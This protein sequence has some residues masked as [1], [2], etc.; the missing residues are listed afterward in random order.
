MAHLPQRLASV[1]SDFIFLGTTENFQ[2]DISEH[3]HW[4]RIR[5]QMASKNG[6]PAGLCVNAFT[7]PPEMLH[8]CVLQFHQAG[9]KRL[10]QDELLQKIIAHAY[11]QTCWTGG[12]ERVSAGKT[13]PV[14]FVAIDRSNSFRNDSQTQNGESKQ[15]DVGHFIFGKQN[16]FLHETARANKLEIFRE[17]GK[18]AGDLSVELLERLNAK[19]FVDRFIGANKELGGRIRIHRF[20]PVSGSH[21]ISSLL[22]PGQ[23]ADF[24]TD[25]HFLKNQNVL[26]A[27]N[28][29][30][31]LNFPEEY[32]NVWCAMNDPVGLLVEN[33][34]LRQLPLSRR[35]AILVDKNGRATIRIVSLADFALKLPWEAA[36]RRAD[37]ERIFFLDDLSQIGKKIVVYSPA[38]QAAFPR[39][40][41][42]SPEGDVVDF[43]VV[44][45]NI[46]EAKQGGGLEIP[47]NGVV[48]SCPIHALPSDELPQL[49]QKFGTHVPFHLLTQKFGLEEIQTAVSAGPILLENGHDLPDHSFEPFD[50][51]EQF[52]PAK[53]RENRTVQAGIVPTRFPHDVDKSRAP[54]TLLGLTDDNKFILTVIDGRDV[55]HSPGATLKEAAGIAK[56]LGCTHALNLDGGGSSVL[57]ID[58]KEKT[59]NPL[60]PGIPKGI[61]NI[62]SDSGHRDRL[63]PAPLLV[64]D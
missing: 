16:I 50:A 64:I 34:R 11:W 61:V 26:A 31:F 8:P 18:F 20:V 5:C 60:L 14:A 41:Q 40:E 52:L 53:W 36:W 56:V 30:F 33:S 37:S 10:L 27:A 43:A 7:F 25:D 58:N 46:V 1:F 59:E 45:G 63:I 17:N 42:M 21:V 57:Y 23:L 19:A 12:A 2:S 44:F 3:T 55:G 6:E 24:C 38:F 49:I 35:G 62:P 47:A 4:Q 9:C 22:Q 39:G 28:S 13:E 15:L 54:R 48:I 51:K 32:S 29:G